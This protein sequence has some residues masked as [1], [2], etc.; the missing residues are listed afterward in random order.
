MLLLSFF[1]LLK[2]ISFYM[3][4]FVL[5][6]HA[7]STPEKNN[8]LSCTSPGILFPSLKKTEDASALNCVLKNE[9]ISQ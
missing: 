5:M 2:F 7:A 4:S 1:W 8:I 3:Q 9:K 6:T